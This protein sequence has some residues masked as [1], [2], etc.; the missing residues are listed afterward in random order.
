[1]FLLGPGSQAWPEECS[2][3]PQEVIKM[4]D[5]TNKHRIGMLELTYLLVAALLLLF[6]G[7]IASRG[8]AQTKQPLY[9]EY[10][11]VGTLK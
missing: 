9:R 3:N 7:V 1:M 10:R 4:K 8:N 5:S 2:M 11:S 6:L